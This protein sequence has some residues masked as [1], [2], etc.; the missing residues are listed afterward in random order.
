[1]LEGVG[2]GYIVESA[3]DS[4]QDG[5]VV[6]GANP[7]ERGS[8][9]KGPQLVPLDV[10]LRVQ[11]LDAATWKGKVTL[12]PESDPKA[13]PLALSNKAGG[14]V[15]VKANNNSSG[16]L[17]PQTQHFLVYVDIDDPDLAILPGTMSQ[18]KIYCRPE[19]CLRWAWRKINDAF[20]LGLI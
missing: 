7:N 5:W 1:V 17:I 20:N 14:P 11:G 10:T 8:P 12:L 13:I 19:T 15:A 2:G 18:V 3:P 9:E 6:L 4:E 16:A